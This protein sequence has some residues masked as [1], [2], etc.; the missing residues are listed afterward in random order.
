[1]ADNKISLYELQQIIRDSLYISFPNFYWVTAEI[2]ELKENFSGHCYLEL[3]EKQS[4]EKNIKAKVR[5][6]I[7]GNRYRFLKSF[8]EDATGESLREGLKVLVRIKLEYHEVFGLSLVI[9]DIDPVFTIG[10][11]AMK[12]QMII[13]RLETEGVFSMNR[14]IELP[15]LT[16]R[17]AVI[18]SKNAAGFTDFTNHIKEN[19]ASYVFYLTLFEAAMQ[20]IETESAI[21]SALE[22]IAINTD[23]YDAVVIIRG[24]G[25]ISDLSWF[26]NY[27]IA[28]Y[29]TQFPLPVITGIG[30]EKDLSV[31]DMVANVSL[32]TP[33]AVA[34]FLIER[35]ALLEETL[36]SL[37]SEITEKSFKVLEAFT[38]RIESAGS[39][40]A[41]L[42]KILL[43]RL[44]E[45]LSGKVL[46]VVSTGKAFVIRSGLTPENQKSRLRSSVKV[47]Y[48]TKNTTLDKNRKN[49]VKFTHS[50]LNNNILRTSR[51]EKSLMILNPINVLKR[52]YTISSF[53]G[54]II[55]SIKEVKENDMLE[56]LFPDG[57][58]KSKVTDK[59]KSDFE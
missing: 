12:R 8:F 35:M 15:S 50:A 57:S 53:K 11:M 25:S 9:S 24:G 1:M 45:K 5:A 31:C 27:N 58:V 4:D 41:P 59:L 18:S 46:E 29:I 3:I 49:L 40:L 52:G 16:Q 21:I 30:H 20:G 13:K 32:K 2:A 44:K 47:F 42:A 43:A 7:W 14:E 48:S 38:R 28:Y 56:T 55:K 26:N 33:T 17:I 6:I 10:E 19:R 39:K 51:L 22:K 54:R 37:S 23:L 34:D 36:L